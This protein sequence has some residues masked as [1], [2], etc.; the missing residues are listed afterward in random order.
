VRGIAQ[1]PAMD[2]RRPASG[3]EAPMKGWSNTPDTGACASHFTK[4]PLIEPT[5]R[6]AAVSPDMAPPP[7]EG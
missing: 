7:R 5:P 6:R 3:Q 2:G 4:L 1:K